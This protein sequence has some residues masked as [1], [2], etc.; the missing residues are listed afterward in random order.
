MSI[1]YLFRA[2]VVN[3]L[4]LLRLTIRCSFPHWQKRRLSYFIFMVGNIVN[5][6]EI[7]ESAVKGFDY[8]DKH[9]FY[10]S[11]NI[12]AITYKNVSC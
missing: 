8:Y 10:C 11:F 5:L 6:D 1:Y 2:P 7:S 3:Q 4:G 12:S 9:C